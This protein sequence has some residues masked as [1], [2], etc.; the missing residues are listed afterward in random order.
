MVVR[1][2][3][4]RRCDATGGIGQLSLRVVVL[5]VS[6]ATSLTTV[7]EEVRRGFSLY[8]D[9]DLL[10]P[11]TNEDRDYTMGFGFEVYQ[12]Q[13]PLYLFG[14]VIDAVGEA[15]GFTQTA[16]RFYQ[17]WLFGSQT[18]T[19][20]DIA[21]P[22]PIFDDRPYASLVFLS[23]KQV[24]ADHRQVLGTELTVGAIGLGLSEQVQKA[25]HGWVRD[26]RDNDHPRD[27]QGWRYQI[28]DGGEPTLRLRLAGSRRLFG[29]QQWDVAG[30]WEA[31]LGFQ[32]NASI[33]T[34]LR[35]GDIASPFWNL[36][37]DPIN[38]GAFVPWLRSD[39]WFVWGA[40]RL[41]AVAYDAL[42][43]G[44]FRDS[45]VTVAA[46]D[47]RRVVWEA[48]VGLTKAWPGLQVTFAV[49]A[50]AG[51]TTLTRAPDEHFWGGIYFSWGHY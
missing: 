11:L 3:G 7:A 28:S 19:P 12:D 18:F 26:W 41:R 17:S 35:L 21:N 34:S 15:L 10:M 29:G 44:Q 22:A 40:G 45:E 49:N 2:F 46:D 9:Q 39:E 38:R 5:L 51:D 4:E 48:G 27:P 8:V 24:V 25:L 43:Q 36:P 23:N 32:A 33:G 47:M 37:Y 1:R 31:N 13:G 6:L 16:G 30:G 14:G 20:D 42:L 50:K